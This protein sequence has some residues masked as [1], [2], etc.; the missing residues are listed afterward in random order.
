MTRTHATTLRTCLGIAAL[1]AATAAPAQQAAAPTAKV[2]IRDMPN[3]NKITVESPNFSARA[4]TPSSLTRRPRE[5]GVIDVTY[6]TQTAPG[7]KDKWIDNVTAVFHVMAE[8]PKPPQDGKRF[9]YYTLRVRYVNVPDG[10][11]RAGVV[12]PPSYLER[13]GSIVAVGCEIT[14]DGADKPA[15]KGEASL[16]DLKSNDKKPDDFWWKN[17][18]VVNNA[19][20]VAKRDGLVERSQS[21]FAL[22]NMDDYEAVK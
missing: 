17:P 14:A 4:N 21:P 12:L 15:E 22:L 2:E 10:D 7:N 16:P 3:L 13:Y 6:R 9:S 5:W 11:H 19:Q 20:L 8:N 18:N 1:L